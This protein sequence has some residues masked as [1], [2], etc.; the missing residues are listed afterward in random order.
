MPRACTEDNV[1]NPKKKNQR[2]AWKQFLI[3]VSYLLVWVFKKIRTNKIRLSVAKNL[4]RWGI[5]LIVLLF[6]TT[7]FGQD[8]YSVY[9]NRILKNGWPTYWRGANAM[10]VYGASSSDMNGWGI[11]IVREY[12]GN[13][14]DNPLVGSAQ[15]INGEWLHSLQAVVDENRRNGKVTI[16][17]PFGWNGMSNPF[18]GK[19]PSQTWWWSEYKVRYRQ[20]ANQFKN[21][22]D[23]WFET[24]NEPYMWD[25]S[26]GYSDDL[27][28][29]DMQQ[30]VD[31]IRS[32]GANNIIV[33]PGAETGQS[34]SVI[35]TK[36]KKLLSG[37]KN[38][39]FDI[40]AYEKWLNDS[41]ANI[42]ARMQRLSDAGFAVIFGEIGPHNASDLMNPVPFLN[43]A[44]RKRSTVIAWLW[45]YDS[46]DRDALLDTYGN[47][48]DNNNYNWGSTY[49]SFAQ[50]YRSST[51]FP[52]SIA[53]NEKLN[54][55]FSRFWHHKDWS[56]PSKA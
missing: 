52:N 15:Y 22:P 26:N 21:Q 50:E 20:I 11:D 18:L 37:R 24:W 2:A 8:T 10:H 45:K 56:L 41:Q 12:I 6:A 17:C 27:W 39:V 25:R 28:L 55:L 33:V 38:I 4:T 3:F 23:V 44:R 40:H 54:S 5:V 1:V 46:N 36:G 34:E 30:M 51:S 48:N 14:R 31:N 16:L 7:A 9:G 53:V 32:T 47:P 43:A 42:E 29:S 49:R 35:L 13:M 19:N